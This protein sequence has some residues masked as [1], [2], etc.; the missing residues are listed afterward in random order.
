MLGYKV[1]S[2]NPTEAA[3]LLTSHCLG[4]NFMTKFSL[5]FVIPILG[6]RCKHF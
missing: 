1:L 6:I 2:P 3:K 5:L 4:C